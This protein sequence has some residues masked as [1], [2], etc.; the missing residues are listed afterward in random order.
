[1]ARTPRTP[2]KRARPPRPPSPKARD[3]FL[4]T[5]ARGYSVSLACTE[6][7]IPRSTAY[8][9]R[10][11]NASFRALWDQALELGLEVLED[12]ALRRAVEGVEDFR[13]DREGYEHP[14]RRYSDVLLIFLI[15]NRIRDRYGDRAL[16]S[17]GGADGGPIEVRLSFDPKGE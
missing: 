5:L 13:L 3:S 8:D 6:S 7:G 14:F 11:R 10:G 9:L 12:E 16:L 15:K 2:K 4:A 17:V 1:M